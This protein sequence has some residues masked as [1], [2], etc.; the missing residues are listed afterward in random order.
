MGYSLPNE[1]FHGK[2]MGA[3]SVIQEPDQYSI[4]Q[5]DNMNVDFTVQIKRN[6]DYIS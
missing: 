2:R 4:F 6:D 1:N 5:D 3:L